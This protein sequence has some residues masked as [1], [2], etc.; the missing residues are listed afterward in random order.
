VSKFISLKSLVLVFL[1]LISL[2]YIFITGKF[3][4]DNIVLLTISVLSLLIMVY[5]FTVM[6][7]YFNIAPELLPG[8]NFV[9][10]GPY[11]F[12]RHPMYSSGSLFLICLIINE[13]SLLRLASLVL[14]IAVFLTKI[15]MEEKILDKNFPGYKLYKAGTR[16]LIPFIY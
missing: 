7:F 15:S 10:K 4:P 13:F 14:L 1:Q 6:K 8:A 2:I 9:S 5:S 12:I 16:K 11:K 3:L